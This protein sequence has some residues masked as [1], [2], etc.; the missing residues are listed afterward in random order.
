MSFDDLDAEPDYWLT[1]PQEV[2]AA[3]FELTHPDSH[4]LVRDPADRELAITI[5]ALDK[6]SQTLYWRPR[7]Y[8]GADFAQNERS[9][10]AGAAF[11]VIAQ[12]Y[13]GVQIRFRIPRPAVV[14]MDD[15]AAAL[16]SPFPQRLARVQRRHAFRAQT[17]AMPGNRAWARWTPPDCP[18]PLE[19]RIRDISVEGIGLRGQIAL[20]EL[21][22]P[23]TVMEDVTLDFGQAGVLS[24]SLKVRNV[25]ALGR[26][27]AAPDAQAQADVQPQAEAPA[28]EP[29]LSH[30]GAQ[31]VDLNARQ[32]SWIQK[33]V[34]QLEKERGNQK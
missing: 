19:F 28:G 2:R 11:D 26:Q 3:L 22:A 24:A 20:S 25:Y 14:H 32:E 15:G 4:I 6:D 34:W 27:P 23:G 1:H 13:S 17:T 16:A 10:L 12:G 9:V 8:A 29:P 31:F 33:V 7:D 5:T 21:P 18:R 30:L